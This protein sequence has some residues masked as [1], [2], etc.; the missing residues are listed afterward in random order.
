MSR[1]YAEV[2]HNLVMLWTLGCNTPVLHDNLYVHC[3]GGT[4]DGYALAKFLYRSLQEPL[5]RRAAS[6][7]VSSPVRA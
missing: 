4:L 2:S 5:L 6:Q 1:V 3:S 7:N